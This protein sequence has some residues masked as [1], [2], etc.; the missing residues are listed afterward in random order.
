[1]VKNGVSYATSISKVLLKQ[2]TL[3]LVLKYKIYIVEIRKY[4]VYITA[5]LRM[6]VHTHSIAAGIHYPRRIALLGR[7]AQSQNHVVQTSCPNKPLKYF[8]KATPTV[9]TDDAKFLR[10]EILVEK[11]IGR[12]CGCTRESPN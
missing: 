7:H 8:L 11:V 2:P 10:H 3:W 4:T 6:Y 12:I 5:L 1:M 9:R